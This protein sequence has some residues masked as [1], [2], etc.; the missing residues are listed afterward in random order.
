[1][2]VWRWPG[3]D[4]GNGRFWSWMTISRPKPRA[5]RY[6][7]IIFDTAGC[8]LMVMPAIFQASATDGLL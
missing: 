7:H 3:A 2:Y 6:D 5:H 4:A 8:D 1:M